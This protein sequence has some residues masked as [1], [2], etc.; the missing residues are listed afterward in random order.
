MKK[1]FTLVLAIVLILSILAGCAG[2]KAQSTADTTAAQSVSQQAE[3]TAASSEQA[4]P[5]NLKFVYWDPNTKDAVEGINNDFVKEN[6][7]VTIEHEIAPGDKY[8]QVI[9]TRSLAGEAPDLFMYFASSVYKMAKDKYWGELTGESWVQDVIP[10]FVESSSYEGKLY[11]LTIDYAGYGV[12]YNKQVFADA[13]ITEMPKTY[14]D[15]LSIC[16]KIKAKGI[17]PLGFGGKDG[18]TPSH[19]TTLL[20][21]AFNTGKNPSWQADLYDGKVKFTDATGY[22]T[23]VEKYAELLDK[24]YIQKGAL[25]VTFDQVAADVA[26][27]KTA[28]VIMGSWAPGT[29][30]GKKPD[31]QLGVFLLPDD[32]GKFTSISLPDKALGYSATGKNTD[33]AKKLISYWAK[34]EVIQKY[35]DVSKSLCAVKGVTAKDLPGVIKD[36]GAMMENAE[37]FGFPNAPWPAS[38]VAEN[39]KGLAA[40]AAGERNIDKFLET[41]QTNYDKDKGTVI[42]PVNK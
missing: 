13:G 24:G 2:N 22:R 35:V 32:T 38:V 42:R 3:T 39:D 14:A 25:G 10:A 12:W 16:E 41:L 21:T 28:M 37:L 9:K 15:F 29:M 33:T 23:M 8:E 7:N 18:W 19:H 34:P 36:L 4:K 27:G 30:L 17:A 40:M 1:V 20:Y 26:N 11:A 31:A 6:P 5:V